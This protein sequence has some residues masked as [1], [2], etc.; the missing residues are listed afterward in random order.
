MDDWS[1][2]T[3]LVGGARCNVTVI[4]DTLLQCKPP[5]QRPVSADSKHLSPAP[6]VT[7]SLAV[8]CIALAN[9]HRQIPPR[10]L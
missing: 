5:D 7:V 1:E 8:L 6:R 9:S 4:T 2:V 10:S 3:V